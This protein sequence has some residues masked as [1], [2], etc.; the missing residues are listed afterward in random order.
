MDPRNI[1]KLH[2]RLLR[3]LRFWLP[4]LL[5]TTVILLASSDLFSAPHT[6]S[7]LETIITRLLGHP[8]APETFELMHYFVRKGGHLT[9]YGILGALY[10]RA[11]RS[12]RPGW[13]WEWAVGAVV[14]TTVIASV[15]EWHQAY[16]P[17]RTGTPG[18]VL[19]DAI[20]ATIAQI[21]L[22]AVLRMKRYANNLH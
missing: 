5:W 13:T 2:S 15:D 1:W 20:G 18:D 3:F 17:T 10:F 6:G 9:A 22:R 4:A 12:G 21:V 11:L 14:V 7:L 8:L 16:V 19:I